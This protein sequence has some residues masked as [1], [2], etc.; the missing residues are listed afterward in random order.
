MLYWFLQW[1]LHFI[2]LG[3]N[4]SQFSPNSCTERGPAQWPEFCVTTIKKLKSEIL[5][6]CVFVT[7]NKWGLEEKDWCMNL[8]SIQAR[9]WE[10]SP[11][12][13][14]HWSR[15]GAAMASKI[16]LTVDLLKKKMPPS[17]SLGPSKSFI[18]LV[19]FPIGFCGTT[20]ILFPFL[21]LFHPCPIYKFLGIER[22]RKQVGSL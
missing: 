14:G 20:D 19:G 11:V 10:A 18:Y 1:F 2:S 3:N 5:W 4:E 6:S 9:Y 17:L 15:G 8:V 21:F 13:R 12:I 16:C 7:E 22:E